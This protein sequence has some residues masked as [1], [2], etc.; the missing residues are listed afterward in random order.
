M[1]FQ[2]AEL[3]CNVIGRQSREDATCVNALL[4]E[5]VRWLAT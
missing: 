5:F 4:G 2:G 1:F 3:S